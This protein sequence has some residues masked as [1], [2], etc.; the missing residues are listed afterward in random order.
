MASHQI[1]ILE[2]FFKY[3]PMSVWLKTFFSKK[4]TKGEYITCA[5]D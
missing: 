3:L 4:I 5:T 1:F 2:I